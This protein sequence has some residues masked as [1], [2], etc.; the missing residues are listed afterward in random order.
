MQDYSKL[1][2]KLGIDATISPRTA[3]ISEITR[4]VRR[5][6]VEKVIS[7][8]SNNA[9]AI[10]FIVPRGALITQNPINQLDLPPDVLI[11]GVVRGGAFNIPVGSTL[12]QPGDHVIVFA[13]PEKIAIA[14]KFFSNED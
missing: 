4:F 1:V 5:G 8:K 3:A 13:L 11:G 14:E 6:H 12:I 9:E 10:E 2:A 7:F